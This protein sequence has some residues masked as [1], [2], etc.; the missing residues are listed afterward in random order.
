[1]TEEDNNDSSD[2]FQDPYSDLRRTSRD[3]PLFHGTGD[4]QD[5]PTSQLGCSDPPEEGP[6]QDPCREPKEPQDP[7]GPP[8]QDRVQFRLRCWLWS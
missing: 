6:P 8:N 4:K 2:S 7:W 1:M 5:Q 3:S